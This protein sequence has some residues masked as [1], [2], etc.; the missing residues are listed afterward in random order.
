MV[1]EKE[2]YPQMAP[3]FEEVSKRFTPNQKSSAIQR[4]LACDHAQLL[5]HRV[6]SMQHFLPFF[7]SPPSFFA[8][9][10]SSAATMAC[11]W[12]STITNVYCH[13]GLP[14]QRHP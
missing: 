8:A 5:F 1:E 10:G 7:L 3:V 4:F 12:I 14:H 6:Q 2:R 11:G 9:G 13:I